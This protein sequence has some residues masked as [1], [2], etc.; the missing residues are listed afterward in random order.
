MDCTHLTVAIILLDNLS[1]VKL[2]NRAP[3]DSERKILSKGNRKQNKTK[4]HGLCSCY[5]LGICPSFLVLTWASTR[6]AWSGLSNQQFFSP[7]IFRKTLMSWNNEKNFQHFLKI[8]IIKVSSDST[9]VRLAICFDVLWRKHKQDLNVFNSNWRH[10]NKQ[11]PWTLHISKGNTGIKFVNYNINQP[12]L[13]CIVLIN[14]A[15]QSYQ[16]HFL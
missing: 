8:P 3:K 16:I 12:Y 7:F 10:F 6:N 1:S 15:L 5:P 11:K 2:G 9:G 13:A 14:L 4:F